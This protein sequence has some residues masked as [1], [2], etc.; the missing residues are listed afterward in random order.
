VRVVQR[1]GR[2]RRTTQPPEIQLCRPCEAG[3]QAT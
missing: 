2:I 1:I 3:R